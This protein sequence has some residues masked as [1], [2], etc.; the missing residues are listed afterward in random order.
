MAALPQNEVVELR[1]RDSIGPMPER[2]A[3]YLEW[4]DSLQPVLTG[5]ELERFEADVRSAR[6]RT[7]STAP[8]WQERIDN[9]RK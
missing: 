6:R 2:F 9:L 4:F 7:K 1:Y 8:K 5:P 3:Q